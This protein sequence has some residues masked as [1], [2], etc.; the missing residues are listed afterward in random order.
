MRFLSKFALALMFP[1]AALV[2]VPALSLAQEAA[3]QGEKPWQS[4]PIVSTSVAWSAQTVDGDRFWINADDF[5][6]GKSWFAVWL[7]GEHSHNPSVSYRTSLW[8]FRFPCNGTVILE[9][10]STFDQSGRRTGTWDS[11]AG[12]TSFI[13]PGTM[14]QQIEKQFCPK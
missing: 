4:D 3:A 13:R 1:A 2:F 10:A 8:R 14:Y 11:L 7:H 6:R 5:E 9:A 12:Q